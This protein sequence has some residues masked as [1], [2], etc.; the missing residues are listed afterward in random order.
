MALKIRASAWLVILPLLFSARPVQAGNMVTSFKVKGNTVTAIFIAPDPLDP[1]VES[2]VSVAAADLLEKVTSAGKTISLRTNLVVVERDTCT[3]VVLFSGEGSSATHSLTVAPDLSSASLSAQITLQDAVST[4]LFPFQ[5]SLS[6]RAIG[7]AQTTNT[8]EK[9]RDPEAGIKITTKS[10]STI[11]D[12]TATGTVSGFGRNH[13]P[14]PS[15]S[16]TIQKQNDG[17][18]V[19]ERNA[20]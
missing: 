15:E 20:P 12:A 6:F 14:E 1:C 2:I 16:A 8:H 10:K 11:V 18:H 4:Q 9:F 3:G 17:T 5:V 13:T 19:V 7:K